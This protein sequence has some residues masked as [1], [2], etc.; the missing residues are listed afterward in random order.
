M[1]FIWRA[2]ENVEAYLVLREQDLVERNIK[3]EI[4]LTH[5]LKD[6]NIFVKSGVLSLITSVSSKQWSILERH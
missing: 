4:L 1:R 6:F 5:T 2:I 3:Q